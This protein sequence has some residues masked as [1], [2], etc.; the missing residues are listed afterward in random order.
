M[1]VICG[2]RVYQVNRT[3]RFCYGFVIV[4]A[5]SFREELQQVFERDPFARVNRFQRREKAS[6]ARC[7]DVQWRWLFS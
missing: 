1:Y 5:Q 6:A 3:V 4:L 7:D 2:S